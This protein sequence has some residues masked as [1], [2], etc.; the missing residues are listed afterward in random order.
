ML[1][2]F[3]EFREAVRIG[4]MERVLSDAAALMDLQGDWLHIQLFRNE[5]NL[6]IPASN[7]KYVELSEPKPGNTRNTRKTRK[8]RKIQY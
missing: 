5:K 1:V 7:I 8:T 4:N 6:A 3:V 2:K